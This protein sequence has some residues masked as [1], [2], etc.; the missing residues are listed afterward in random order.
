MT[1]LDHIEYLNVY[2][3]YLKKEG[4]PDIHLLVRVS[5]PTE[6]A[7]GAWICHAEAAPISSATAVPGGSSWE[8][9]YL[10]QKHLVKLLLQ[11]E[12]DG[13]SIH[14]PGSLEPISAKKLFAVD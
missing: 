5:N 6:Q 7:R 11:Q 2:R 10:A 3:L 1:L 14:W 4:K 13:W 8:A 9:F 12:A